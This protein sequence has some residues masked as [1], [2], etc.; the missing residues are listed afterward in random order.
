MMQVSP[1]ITALIVDDEAPAR[2]RLRRMLEEYPNLRIVGEA[3]DG[4]QALALLGKLRPQVV[5]LDIQM[6]GE[7]GLELAAKI[8]PPRPMIVFCTAYE[9]HALEAFALNAVDYLLKP[10]TRQAL[11]RALRKI[12]AEVR[13]GSE[14]LADLERA[15]TTQG[16]LLADAHFQF[17][18]LEV[19]GWFRPA[20]W[21]SGDF[22][23]FH[24]LS[25]D[26]CG[27]TLGDVSGKGVAAALRM[28]A[29][30]G[31][32]R[33]QV[34]ELGGAPAGLVTRLNRFCCEIGGDGGFISLVYLL[35]HRGERRVTY[36][37]AGHFPPL[38]FHGGE[39][40]ETLLSPTGPVLGLLPGAE[41][42][43]A[44]VSLGPGDWIVLYS[45][46]ISDEL[47]EYDRE[48]GV[49]RIRSFVAERTESVASA[50]EMRDAFVDYWTC[51][52]G[53]TPAEDDATILILRG[54]ND[55][56]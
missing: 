56:A 31:W 21:V 46:G 15:E 8:P 26:A 29:V 14:L 49:E 1:A 28:A 16:R 7:N 4:D 43:V 40:A 34:L 24:S 53:A 20:R 27:I 44:Q 50:R 23:D 17:P 30:Q 52:A 6:P 22:F 18:G 36:V 33:A 25:E 12:R 51:F 45:D 32:M 41:Y 35:F 19:A 3:E 11:D 9:R 54:T 10:V 2:A 37:N 13:T 48:F 47:D 55:A 5:F 42:E 39:E 38:H